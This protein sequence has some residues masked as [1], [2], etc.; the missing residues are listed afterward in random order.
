VPFVELYLYAREV[1]LRRRRF[2]NF[3]PGIAQRG[4][5]IT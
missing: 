4:S 3:Q 2:G 1:A 5:E